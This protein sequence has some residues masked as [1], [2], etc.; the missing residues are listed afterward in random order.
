MDEK[1]QTLFDNA[2]NIVFLTGAGVSTA[3]GIPDYRSKGGL[4]DGQM[5]LP[6]YL[7]STEA[8]A[9]EPAKMYDFIIKNMYFPAAQPNVIHQKMAQLVN[10]GRALIITQNVD[11]LHLKAGVNAERV[12]EFHGNI[13]DVYAPSDE[14]SASYQAYMTSLY[15]AD[16]ALLRPNITLYGEIPFRTNEAAQWVA[17]ADL[18]VI[19]GTSFVVYPFAGLLQYAN[20]QAQILAVNL[21]RIEAP[22]YVSQEI[23][24]AT[25]FFNQLKI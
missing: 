21:E 13:Y 11:G 16:G 14:Q 20:M 10:A 4:Y 5:E 3:S 7:L 12:I 6:E 23:G 2:K 15:R 9:H 19:V 25:T 24:D 1:I 8:L 17:Q 18:I 22:R